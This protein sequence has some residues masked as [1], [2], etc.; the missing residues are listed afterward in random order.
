M[1]VRYCE[2]T[3]DR[4]VSPQCWENVGPEPTIGAIVKEARKAG[5]YVGPAGAEEDACPECRG[6][7]VEGHN[8]QGGTFVVEG[9]LTEAV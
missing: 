2:V 9:V 4:K 7:W 6:M 1:R 5:W 3:C 8:G